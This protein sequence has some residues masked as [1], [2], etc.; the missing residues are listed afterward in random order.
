[1]GGPGSGR[2]PSGRAPRTSGGKLATPRVTRKVTGKGNKTLK[3]GR[4]T[5]RLNRENLGKGPR[6][7]SKNVKNRHVPFPL[8]AKDSKKLSKKGLYAH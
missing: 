4:V 1:M 6:P 5:R 8:L 7:P 3:I 2:R